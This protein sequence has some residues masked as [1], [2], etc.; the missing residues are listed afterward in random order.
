MI[1][2][3]VDK[4]KLTKSFLNKFIKWTSSRYNEYKKLEAI[5]IIL[6]GFKEGRTGKLIYHARSY[7][8]CSNMAGLYDYLIDFDNKEIVKCYLGD[9]VIIKNEIER[10][11]VD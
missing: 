4:M 8:P 7:C 2:I 6:A 5:N 10:I 9:N 3:G 11:K 1:N